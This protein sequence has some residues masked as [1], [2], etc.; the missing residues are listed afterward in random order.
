M[1]PVSGIRNASSAREGIVWITPTAASTGCATA[2]DRAATTPR[3][4][5]T[6]IAPASETTTRATCS[7][8]NRA[9]SG[10]KIASTRL[11]ARVERAAPQELRGDRGEVAPVELGVGVQRGSSWARRC[12]PRAARSRPTPSDGARGPRCRAAA[13]RRSAENNPRSSSSTRDVVA[14][15][16]RVGGIQVDRIHLARGERLVR[17][18]VVEAARRGLRQRV[19]RLQPRPAVVPPEELVGEPQPQVREA[20]KVGDAP[21]AVAL[22]VLRA[23]APRRRYRKSRARPR[24]RARAAAAAR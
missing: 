9:K 2:R 7:P 19:G 14:R 16:L 23:A 6:T 10:A 8:S 24:P 12:A 17:E 5:A 3:G 4:T 21:D 1:V 13:P 15:D 20:G 18:P 22:G 11:R